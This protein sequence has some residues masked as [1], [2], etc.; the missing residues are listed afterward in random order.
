MTL[1]IEMNVVV[2]PY[3]KFFS[4][5][6]GRVWHSDKFESAI[7]WKLI[8]ALFATPCSNAV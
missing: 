2:H 3:Q 1:H 7:F 5:P 6:L 8:F 4:V